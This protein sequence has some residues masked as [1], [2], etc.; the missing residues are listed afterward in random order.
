MKCW[1]VALMTN[2]TT[3]LTSKWKMRVGKMNINW[4]RFLGVMKSFPWTTKDYQNIFTNFEVVGGKVN[5]KKWT[6]PRKKQVEISWRMTN[7]FLTQPV[8]LFSLGALPASVQGSYAEARP[9]ASSGHIKRPMN[10]FMVWAKDERRRILQAFPDMHNSSISKILGEPALGRGGF[11]LTSL[12]WDAAWHMWGHELPPASP[13]AHTY[14]PE[15]LP[16]DPKFAFLCIVE[17]LFGYV[18]SSF[19]QE[20]TR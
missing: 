5:I 18:G 12:F 8:T 20:H 14:W 15:S 10:A 19:T 17:S 6:T 1:S 4:R 11:H 16:L 7:I 13:A 2:T 3:F 9:P